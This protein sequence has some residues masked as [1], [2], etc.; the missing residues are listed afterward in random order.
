MFL[1]ETQPAVL[2]MQEPKLVNTSQPPTKKHYHGILFSHP[3]QHTGVVM[4]IHHTV[5]CHVVSCD[6]HATPY[7]PESSS[8]VVRFFWLSSPLLVQPLI[9]GGV[10]LSQHAGEADVVEL[11][12]IAL[13]HSSTSSLPVLLIGDFKSRHP[14]WDRHIHRAPQGLNKW[15]HQHIIPGARHAPLTLLNTKFQQSPKHHTHQHITSL[16]RIGD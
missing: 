4:Y 3:T 14:S 9:L 10:Y 12:R 13:H 16:L 6:D 2:V 8:T 11:K 1:S 7:H 5:S 15:V